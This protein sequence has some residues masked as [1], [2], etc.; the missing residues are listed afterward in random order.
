MSELGVDDI[1]VVAISKGP[2]RNAGREQFHIDGREPFTLPYDSAS[3][4]FCSAC[5][6]R[7]T[8]LRLAATAHAAPNRPLQTP[9][10]RYQVSGQNV[11]AL[12]AHFGS[13]KA[14][15]RAGVRDLT[16]VEGI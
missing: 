11:K 13:A 4:I 15:S 7:R 2:D 12:L 9:L 14:I 1:A 10:I 6:M 5:V 3:C 8:V 16:A